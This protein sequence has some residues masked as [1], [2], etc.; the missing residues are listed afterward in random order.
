MTRRDPRSLSISARGYAT[1]GFVANT[2]FCASD[3]GLGRGFTQYEDFIF[4]E[5][6]A[7][8]SAV[9][10]TR[11]LA[12][13]G[14]LLPIVEERPSLAWLRPHVQQLWRRFVFD[15]KGAAAVNREVLEWLSGRT[16]PER[17]F[18]AFLNY[19]DA[20]TPYE[21][22]TGRMHRFG[23]GEPDERQRELIK[24]SGGTGQGSSR[25]KG[26]AFRRRCLRRLHRRPR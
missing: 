17:P 24:R 6:S 18:F 15:R 10:A 4:P 14:R 25:V 3:T 5:Y 19:S 13:F 9:L 26:F 12:A 11:V 2:M 23:V 20:H 16:Q 21:L 22:S 1:A 7:L 8:K